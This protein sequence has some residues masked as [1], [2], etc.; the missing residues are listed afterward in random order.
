MIREI[1]DGKIYYMEGLFTHAAV[2]GRLRDEFT[3]YFRETGNK[4]CT[5]FS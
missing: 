4:N 1:I 5:A 2:I 3:F